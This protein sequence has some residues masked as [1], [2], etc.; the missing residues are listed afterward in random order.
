MRPLRIALLRQGYSPFGGAERYVERLSHALQAEGLEVTLLTRAWPAPAAFSVVRCDPFHLGRLWRDVGF[1]YQ[2]HRVIAARRFDLVQ[3]HER[4]AACDIYRAGDGV[5]RE[6][7]ARR[8]A[9]MGLLDRARSRLSPYQR[10]ALWQ[11]ARVF[12]S[13]RLRAVVCN[14]RM[15]KHDVM[16][17]YAVPADKLHVIYPGVDAAYF[18]PALKGQY[19]QAVRNTYAIPPD[20]TVLLFVGSGFERKGVRLLLEAIAAVPE[21]LHLLVVGY[22]ARLQSYASR[23]ANLGIGARV[24]FASGQHDVRPFYGAA[25]AFVLPSLYEPFGAAVQE[26]MAVGLPIVT[27][28][29]TGAAELI[30]HGESGFVC[31]PSDLNALVTAL[32]HLQSPALRDRMG[33]MARKRVEPMTLETMGRQFH[34]LYDA[35]LGVSAHPEEAL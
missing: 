9:G 1:A 7:L 15:V 16:A 2:S 35:V 13:P 26:A 34:D 6:W 19:R 28:T 17:H 20:A 25:D 27:S 18:A 3:S 22:D 30:E 14:S 24:H 29:Q 4:I 33:A 23:A 12:R 8:R 32:R 11:E 31:E 10:F 5:H 21:P